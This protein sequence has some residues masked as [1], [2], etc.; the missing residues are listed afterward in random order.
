M[1]R[2]TYSTQTKSIVTTLGQLIQ[3]ARKE[4]GMSAAD[5]A[6]RAGIAR[7]TLTRIEAGD[8]SCEIGVVFELCVILGVPLYGSEREQSLVKRHAEE[9][10]QLLPKRVRNVTPKV[11]NDF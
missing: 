3:I 6:T 10:L 9:K 7:G 1:A 4:R 8:P 2:R 5:V 11:D